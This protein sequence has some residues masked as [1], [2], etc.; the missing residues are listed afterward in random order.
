MSVSPDC[1]IHLT[2][3]VDQ[4]CPHLSPN[5]YSSYH[6]HLYFLYSQQT[7]SCSLLRR[8]RLSCPFT[9]LLSPIF[10]FF[11]FC[12][13]TV[14][15]L[16]KADPCI[17]TCELITFSVILYHQSSCTLMQFNC[18]LHVDFS[19]LPINVFKSSPS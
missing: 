10:F 6:T 1:C 7:T 8:N 2:N 5:F 14:F 17:C 19:P 3:T 9:P 11:V 16:V 12:W 15:I 18:C 13:E 4:L